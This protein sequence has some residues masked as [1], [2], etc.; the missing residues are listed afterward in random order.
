MKHW[1]CLLPVVARIERRENTVHWSK[2]WKPPEISRSRS[3]LYVTSS[4]KSCSCTTTIGTLKAYATS[5]EWWLIFLLPVPPSQRLVS[6]RNMTYES[7]AHS[8]QPNKCSNT[9]RHIH[10]TY[11]KNNCHINT[12][13]M[14]IIICAVV[15]SLTF[16]QTCDCR[17]I[18]NYL[19]YIL[20]RELY[21]R[22]ENVASDVHE[23]HIQVNQL[24]VVPP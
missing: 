2:V 17:N 18:H 7:W 21:K 13:Y 10:L 22:M 20:P 3:R 5:V 1:K 19:K 24:S 8:A 23:A 9:W 11:L 16:Y 12:Q 14:Y 15:D 6:H 4:W